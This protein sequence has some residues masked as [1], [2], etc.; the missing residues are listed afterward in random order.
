MQRQTIPGIQ[1]SGICLLL[2]LVVTASIGCS[3][4]KPAGAA[5]AASDKGTAPAELPKN[6]K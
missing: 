5:N 1:V 6:Q 4:Y 3:E 2:L